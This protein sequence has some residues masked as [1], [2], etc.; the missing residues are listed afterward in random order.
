[1]RTLTMSVLIVVLLGGSIALAAQEDVPRISAQDARYD[2]GKV[3]RGTE[4][5]H[6]FEITNT[7]T[8]PLVIG[9]L[10]PS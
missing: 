1:M 10:Q 2:A 6:V 4:V 8:A 3:K 5:T 9:R 7:G